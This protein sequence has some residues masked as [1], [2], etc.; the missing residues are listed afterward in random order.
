MDAF[1]DGEEV[2]FCR[3]DDIVGGT[4]SSGLVGRLLNDLELLLVSAEEPPTFALVERDANWRWSMLEEMKAI[5]ENKTWELI[6]PP[7]GCCPIDLKWVYKMKRDKRGAIVKYKARLVAHGFVQREGIDF[8]EAFAPVAQMKSVRLLLAM[9]AAKDWRVHHLDVKSAFLNGELA[10]TVFVK[11]APGFAVKGAEHKVL[12]LRKA[13]YGLRQAPRVWNAKLEA[14]LGEL[15]FTHCATEHALYTQRRGKEE[16]GGGVYV[17]DLIV[18]GARAED[19]DGFKREM[20]A[21]FKMSDLSALSYYLGIEVRQEKQIISLGQHAYA[22][23]LL[24]DG[25][26]QAVR[27]SDG[28]AAEAKQA[29]HCCKGG[30]DALPEH[31]QW[32]VLPHSYP[33]G[34]CVRGWVRQ[35]FH[36]GPARRLLVGSEKVA[37]LRQGDARS[38]DHLPQEWW[39]GRVAAHGVQ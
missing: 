26:V 33:I 22:E 12:K 24:E 10:E 35:P 27:D 32:A 34:H 16:L 13:L 18:T 4:G 28:G 20:A 14:T 38:S 3:L 39:Q 11:Q 1:H 7:P 2:R 21:R 9:A 23:K 31:R 29:Q 5:E 25:G 37:V 8:E 30:R 19:I 6:D 17:D 36:G 15:G